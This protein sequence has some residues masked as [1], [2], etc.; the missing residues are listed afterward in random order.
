MVSQTSGYWY[1]LEPENR[2]LEMIVCFLSALCSLSPLGMGCYSPVNSSASAF[3]IYFRQV[4]LVAL[5]FEEMYWFIYL[6][7]L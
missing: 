7:E 5:W 6:L 3:Q 2:H 1:V 4:Q